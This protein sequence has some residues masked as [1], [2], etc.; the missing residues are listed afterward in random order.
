MKEF[1]QK[2]IFKVQKNILQEYGTLTDCCDIAC[3]QVMIEL[4]KLKVSGVIVNG[5]IKHNLDKSY[6]TGHHW[7]IVENTILDPT[8]NQFGYEKSIMNFD[9][10]EYKDNYIYKNIFKEF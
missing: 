5:Q 7:I 4:K 6:L 10:H 9:E 1:Y 8:A 3:E 2:I